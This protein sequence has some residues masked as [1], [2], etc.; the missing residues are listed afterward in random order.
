MEFADYVDF[1]D[2]EKLQPVAAEKLK[3]NNLS[4]NETKTEFSHVYLAEASETDLHGK[5]LRGNESG[6]RTRP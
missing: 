4:M 3:A 5:A 6:S 1:L 2:E